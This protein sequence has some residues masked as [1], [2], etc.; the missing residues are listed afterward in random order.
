MKEGKGKDKNG[1]WR[2]PTCK[3][4]AD[5][6]DR[7]IHIYIEGHIWPLHFDCELGNDIDHI[8]FDKLEKIS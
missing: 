4:E 3:V 5:V 8:N 2:C 6:K 7:E 1:R